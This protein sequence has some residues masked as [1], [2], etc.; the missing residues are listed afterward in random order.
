MGLQQELGLPHPVADPTHEA[1]LGVVLTGQLLAKEG[2]R[3]VQPFGLTDSQFNVMMLLKYQAAGGV[4]QTRLGRM[5]L[6]NRSN[7]SGLV[8]R[9][10]EAGMVR[11]TAEAADQRVN[12]IVLTRKGRS[13]LQRA[14][15]AYFRRIGQVVKGIPKGDRAVVSIALERMRRS[16]RRGKCRSTDEFFC[17]EIVHI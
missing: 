10:E 8:D 16:L 17:G 15:R 5:L 7:V 3:V 13:I 2:S 6:V 14:E 9:M 11:R 12:R 4:S 1:V